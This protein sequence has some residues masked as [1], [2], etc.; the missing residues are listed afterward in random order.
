VRSIEYASTGDVAVVD[1]AKAD[2]ANLHGLG[3]QEREQPE[4][5]ED[6]TAESWG[7]GSHPEPAA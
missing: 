6:Q 4:L 2:R 5:W 1:L 3:R 7:V